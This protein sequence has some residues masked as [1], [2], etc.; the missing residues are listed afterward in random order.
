MERL[1]GSDPISLPEEFASGLAVARERLGIFA[2]QI[3]WYAEVGSTNDL[4]SAM[5]D[6]NAAEG[7]VVLA[8]RQTAGRGRL[9]R[10]WASPGG[11][12][13]YA[14]VV[15]RPSVTAATLLTIAAGVA[16]AEGIASA[17]GLSPHV[18]WPND[19]QVGGRKLAGILAEGAVGHVVLGIGINVQSAAFPP[20][21]AARATSIEAELSRPVDRGLVL[22][23]CL[24]ALAS[25]YRELQNGRG[26]QVVD[27]WRR[28]AAPM[29]G[30]PV[31]WESA[32]THLV[33][34]AENIDD[35]GALIVKVGAQTQKIRSGE[36]R[37][38]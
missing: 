3:L 12:G 1:K 17:T 20:D 13:V 14:S 32:G 5:A 21:V 36:V 6:R 25:R 26:R 9:G 18:K 16:V 37:W 29:L 24:A 33:G 2:Q 23:E 22:A 31:E 30:R 15:L 34:L 38:L 4:A 28:R 19:V 10:T 7:L 35:E 8:D 11:A 27:A